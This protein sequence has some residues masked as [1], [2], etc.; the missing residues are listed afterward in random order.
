MAPM[1]AA[2]KKPDRPGVLRQDVHDVVRPRQPLADAVLGD[3]AYAFVAGGSAPRTQT[4]FIRRGSSSS[5]SRRPIA[6]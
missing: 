3:D 2:S 5:T 6:P 1:R 4:T